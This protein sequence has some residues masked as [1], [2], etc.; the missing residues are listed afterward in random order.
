MLPFR[1][2]KRRGLL[3]CDSAF[4]FPIW[5]LRSLFSFLLVSLSSDPEVREGSL[6]WGALSVPKH[7][8]ESK[9]KDEP[10]PLHPLLVTSSSV[11]CVLV[12]SECPAAAV[13]EFWWAPLLSAFSKALHLKKEHTVNANGRLLPSHHLSLPPSGSA[14]L[15]PAPRPAVTA[16]WC[17]RSFVLLQLVSGNDL[18]EDQSAGG[19]N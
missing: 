9:N 6:H 11:C 1:W 18:S 13:G 8:L 12:M 3:K 2:D 17:P 15:V 7:P 10:S 14:A 16:G 5:C 19:L 4:A